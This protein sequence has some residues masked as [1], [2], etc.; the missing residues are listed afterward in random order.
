MAQDKNKTNLEQKET[1]SR[2]ELFIKSLDS[3]GIKA[4]YDLYVAVSVTKVNNMVAKELG[5]NFRGSE[6]AIFSLGVVS[7]ENNIIRQ[8]KAIIERDK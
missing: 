2:E 3:K 7:G 6:L 1:T 8:F 5:S 4:L